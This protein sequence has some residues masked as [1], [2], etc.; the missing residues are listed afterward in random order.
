L[1]CQVLDQQGYPRRELVLT[2]GLSKTP[3]CGQILADVFDTP[4]TLLASADEGCSWGA[5]VLAKYRHL[6][7]CKDDYDQDWSSF[8]EQVRPPEEQVLRFSPNP[9]HVAVYE[10][11]FTRYQKLIQLQSQLADAVK[12]S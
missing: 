1:G 12:S 11:M 10:R 9:E 5:A 3:A 8:L 4:V 6:C 7:C 2:G